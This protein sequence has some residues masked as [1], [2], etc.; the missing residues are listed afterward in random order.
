MKFKIEFTVNDADL[1]RLDKNVL[2]QSRGGETSYQYIVRG[3]NFF[4]GKIG[5]R[6]STI[7]LYTQ[8]SVI[9]SAEEV[10]R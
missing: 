6:H 10:K 7:S 1:K 2:T 9:K 5:L 4:L 3:I 8:E